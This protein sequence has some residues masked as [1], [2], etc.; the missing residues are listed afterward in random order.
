MPTKTRLLLYVILLGLVDA[1]IP[2]FPILAIVLVYVLFV[3]PT[4]FLEAV[5]E[6]Y[7]SN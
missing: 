3:K 2:F 1:V 6:I 4:W 7:R 5:Q